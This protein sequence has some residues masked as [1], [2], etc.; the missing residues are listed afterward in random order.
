MELN[1]EPNPFFGAFIGGIGPFFR[2]RV[3][4]CG[5]YFYASEV[6]LSVS[7]FGQFHEA[8][9]GIQIPSTLDNLLAIR[10]T[11]NRLIGYLETDIELIVL[12]TI[13]RNEHTS[14][15]TLIS[16]VKSIYNRH[17][18]VTEREVFQSIER[19]T[20]ARLIGSQMRY[21][22]DDEPHFAFLYNTTHS[23]LAELAQSEKHLATL[24]RAEQ[25]G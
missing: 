4:S 24:I 16:Q 11:L 3:L 21:S 2:R 6:S 8:L 25:A 9:G 17:D 7:V 23:G 22:A 13:R 14:S 5:A 10:E 18:I 19:L 15:H 20:Q 1:W 12:E